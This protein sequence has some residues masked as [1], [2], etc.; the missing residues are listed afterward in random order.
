[1][2]LSATTDHDLILQGGAFAEHEI[3]SV[4]HTAG[5]GEWTGSFYAYIGD[6]PGERSVTVSNVGPY[7]SIH[8]PRGTRIKLTLNLALREFKQ[9]Y[10][11]PW[12]R[13]A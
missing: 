4:T 3:R 13:S 10:L 9:T 6:E 5:D 7:V 2:N 11:A 8:L 12:E 1:M